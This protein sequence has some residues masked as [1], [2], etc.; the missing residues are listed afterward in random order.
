MASVSPTKVTGPSKCKVPYNL[1]QLPLP[2]GICGVSLCL[3]PCVLP[4]TVRVTFAIIL[5]LDNG[6]ELS[7]LPYPIV[8][9]P[10]PVPVHVY[11]HMKTS[12]SVCC[13]TDT[14]PARTR[15]TIRSAALLA[16]ARI[17]PA[18]ASC[19]TEGAARMPATVHGTTE[20]ARTRVSRISG[21]CSACVQRDS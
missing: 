5:C 7:C 15:A 3:C 17:Y 21:A 8:M 20:D 2:F 19:R 18:L 11:S 9:Q 12:T 10:E 13:A 16:P 6:I 14:D 4:I 1:L